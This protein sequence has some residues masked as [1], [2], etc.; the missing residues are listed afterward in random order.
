MKTEK[1]IEELLEHV[2]HRM[3]VAQCNAKHSLQDGNTT[4]FEHYDR[5]YSK[6]VAQYNILLEVLK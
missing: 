2:K 5:E 1:Q 4:Y 6:A 3:D